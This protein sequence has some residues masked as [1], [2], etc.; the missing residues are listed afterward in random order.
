[1]DTLRP[2]ATPAHDKALH[3]GSGGYRCDCGEEYPC[4]EEW[5]RHTVISYGDPTFGQ[6]MR[7]GSRVHYQPVKV[8]PHSHYAPTECTNV[9]CANH[10]NGYQCWHLVNVELP[11][12]F[13]LP[14]RAFAVALAER[15]G[16]LAA[17]YAVSTC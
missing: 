10:A 4:L 3:T 12:I 16:V 17:R 7:R 11:A 8:E 5:D 9:R 6:I 14:S 15:G 2:V 13:G 1:M